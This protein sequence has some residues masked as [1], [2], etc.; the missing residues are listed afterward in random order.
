M[1]IDKENNNLFYCSALQEAQDIFGVDISFSDLENF[2]D[3]YED[4]ESET[5]GEQEFVAEDPGE[6]RK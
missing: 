3:E 6:H 2:D 1:L 5:E 4:E